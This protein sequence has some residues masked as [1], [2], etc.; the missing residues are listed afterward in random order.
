MNVA[1]SWGEYSK[2]DMRVGTSISVANFPEA[3]NP[4]YQV[5]VDFGSDLGI[6]KS[7][8]Q[9]TNLHTEGDLLGKQVRAMNNFPK[10]KLQI[11]ERMS[12]LGGS[13]G[14]GCSIAIA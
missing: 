2:I 3:R 9:I 7:F 5:K 14:E 1:K 12:Y 6:K 13:S 4:A 8:L 10:N 11:Y